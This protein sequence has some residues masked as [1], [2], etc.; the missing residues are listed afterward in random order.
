[1][2]ANLCRALGCA[3]VLSM[4]AACTGS[5]SAPPSASSTQGHRSGSGPAV[6]SAPPSGGSSASRTG[7]A[8]PKPVPSTRVAPSVPGTIKQT[9]ASGTPVPLPK[10][11]LASAVRFR[12][13]PLTARVIGASRVHAQ[14]HIPG[15]ISGPALSF[16]LQFTNRGHA[17]VDLGSNIAV[18]AQDGTGTPCTALTTS[19]HQ[20]GGTLRPGAQASGHYEFHLPDNTKNPVT[21]EVTY[22]ATAE[23]ARFV[24][25]I[26]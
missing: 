7:P 15:E 16:E 25:P 23:V 13:V 20:V 10:A 17:A 6:S 2:R 11:G 14:A 5:H 9:V 21:I 8:K 4:L 19:T 3:G 22:A 26:S 18:T 24:G 12:S 1:M